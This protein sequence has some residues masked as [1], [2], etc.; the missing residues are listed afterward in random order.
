M[1]N[2]N[3]GHRARIGIF[4]VGAEAVPEAEWW[5]MVPDGVSIHAAR[6]TA[7][8][9]WA[10]WH[11]DRSGVTLAPDLQR[12]AEQLA[13]LDLSA[14][15]VAHS[16]SSV[17][18]GDGWDAA[19]VKALSAHMPEPTRITTNGTDC[20]AALNRLGVKRPFLVFPPWFTQAPVSAGLGYFAA[21]GFIV[22]GHHRNQPDLQWQGIAPQDLYASRM[23]VAQNVEAL[24]DQIIATCPADA[25]GVMIVGTGLRCV[26]IIDALEAA[27]RR[28]VITANQASLWQCLTL[29]GVDANIPGYGRL[30]NRAD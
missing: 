7:K 5:A 1:Q 30:L 25:D 9:P 14:A 11:A 28:P 17:V 18:G 26:A 23:H 27:L 21:Q 6:V 10:T 29:S 13:A 4:I 2:D 16:S 19:T 15:V 12:G 3:W 8:A 20:V 24:A 22:A